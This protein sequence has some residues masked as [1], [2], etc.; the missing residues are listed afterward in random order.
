VVD[1]IV[2]HLG[3]RVVP[4]VTHVLPQPSHHWRDELAPDQI[5]LKTVARSGALNLGQRLELVSACARLAF[6]IDLP[7]AHERLKVTV[8]YLAR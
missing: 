5:L 7:V 8:R 2:D 3:G 6:S 1:R 4:D